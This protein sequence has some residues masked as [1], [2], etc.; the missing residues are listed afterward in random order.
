MALT[1]ECGR[2]SFRLADHPKLAA[3]EKLR[4]VLLLFGYLASDGLPGVW[5]GTDMKLDCYQ[6]VNLPLQEC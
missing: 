4:I 1:V 2:Q 3:G 5:R 6:R